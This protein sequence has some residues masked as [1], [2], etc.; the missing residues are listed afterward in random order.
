MNY[1]ITDNNYN[2]LVKKPS[3]NTE[4]VMEKK[5]WELFGVE[6]MSKSDMENIVKIIE[7]RE[8]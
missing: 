7:F 4:R 2:R 1:M 3:I 6:E 5:P 8:G